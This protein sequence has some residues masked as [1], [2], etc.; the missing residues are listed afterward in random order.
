[1]QHNC[2]EKQQISVIPLHI[3]D[4]AP[5]VAVSN[6]GKAPVKDVLVVD[7]AALFPHLSTGGLYTLKA[8]DGEKHTPVKLDLA[9]SVEACL[10]EI[11]VEIPAEDFVTV[12]FK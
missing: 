2:L 8:Y 6:Y 5:V 12:E 9:P 11:P 4:P 7:L 10:A 3:S 1:M